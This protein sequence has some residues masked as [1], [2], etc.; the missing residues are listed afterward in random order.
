MT[1]TAKI[2]KRFMTASHHVVIPKFGVLILTETF[3]I[4]RDIRDLR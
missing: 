2:T 3:G 1:T 4:S